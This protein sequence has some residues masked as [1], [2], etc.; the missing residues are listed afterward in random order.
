MNSNVDIDMMRLEAVLS[1][2]PWQ[3]NA[4]RQIQ[5]G[6]Y[7]IQTPAGCFGLKQI[8]KPLTKME[9]VWGAMEYLPEHGF[10]KLPKLVKTN[11]ADIPLV[12]QGDIYFVY[13]WLAGKRADFACLSDLLAAAAAL[14][15]FHKAARDLALPGARASYFNKLSGLELMFKDLQGWGREAKCDNSEFSRLYLELLP[16]YITRTQRAL[17]LLE[18]V[19]Y[20]KQAEAAATSP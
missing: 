17:K 8:N 14:A 3:V 13:Q 6:V 7:Q 19:N 9:F 11:E 2:Y 18:R 1:H 16:Y 20:V 4:V 10:K 15:G 12:F 5:K